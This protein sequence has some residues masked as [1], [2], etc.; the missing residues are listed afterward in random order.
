M[1]H[2]RQR[3]LQRTHQ[4]RQ[5]LTVRHVTRDDPHLRTELLQPGRQLR[6]T[7]RRGTTP[8]HQQQTLRPVLGDQVPRDPGT[9]TT[10]TAR[11]EDRA[12][13]VERRRNRE[14]DLAGVVAL[15]QEAEGP[16]GVAD[17]PG[18]DRGVGERALLE[19]RDDPRQHLL[20]PVHAGVEQVE[21]A[22]PHSGVRGGHGLRVAHVRL[23]HLDEPAAVRQ[24]VER[25]VDELARQRVEHH[26]QAAGRLQERVPETEVARRG[27]P[28]VRYAERAH[29]VPLV[30]ARGGVDLRTEVG[31]Q[32]HRGHADAARRGVHQHAVP[33][34]HTGQVDQA[35]VG[36]EV[37]HRH[38][39]R[40]GERP[41]GGHRHDHPAVGDGQRAEALRDEA[42]HPVA[43]G[44]IGHVG[45]DFE[46]DTRGLAAQRRLVRVQ[47][48]RDQYVPEVQAG[49]THAD[50]DLARA[51]RPAALRRS[52]RQIVQRALPAGGQPPRVAGRSLGRPAEPR[53]EHPAVAQREL[54]LV[55][56]H[57]RRPVRGVVGVDGGV[58]VDQQEPARVL[59]LG[60]AH[61]PPHRGLRH[62]RRLVAHGD[63]AA[64]H[65]D[66]PRA[67]QPFA[68]QPSPHQRQRPYGGVAGRVRYG[69]HGRRHLGYDHVRCAPA[70]G[71]RALQGVEVRE[72][73]AEYGDP[74]GRP[75]HGDL[76]PVHPEQ[77][78]AGPR[79]ALQLRRVDRAEDEL[80]HVQHRLA[81]R[82]DDLHAQRRVTG[83]GEPHPGAGRS[84][85]TEAD[86]GPGERKDDRVARALL[87]QAA[88]QSGVEQSG[89]DAEAA[90]VGA[91]RQRDLRVDLVVQAPYGPHALEQRSVVVAEVRHAGVERVDRSG[92]GTRRRP[93]LRP[94]GGRGRGIRLGGEP[95]ASV[96]DRPL[97]LVLVG[98]PA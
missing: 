88:V 56:A 36:G 93:H 94:L 30:R 42:E 37:D 62:V 6:G 11:D 10:R 63:A 87:Q 55:R 21:R 54:R 26:V 81:V 89:V 45:P 53:C 8:A 44:Q 69:T 78:V 23:A 14:D 66:Q 48:E 47:A 49:G 41:A 64:R 9:Q 72:L 27:D 38:R 24:Q 83:R 5:L 67:G 85:G 4:A 33:R 73:P 39:G 98:L 25:R 91:V 20:Q 29:R 12:L 32:L 50:A 79:G 59:G 40:F 7:F 75:R 65:H 77:R 86:A 71:E 74:P 31:G 28:L 15:P 46:H 1:H 60:T 43:G 84:A 17:V 76:G 18:T 16:G 61:Q 19:E 96:T 68:G 92:L 13:R 34:A 58:G 70:L 35:E 97:R 2:C 57:E 95:A 22:V 82:A 90:V 3:M 80:V 52:D 51:E